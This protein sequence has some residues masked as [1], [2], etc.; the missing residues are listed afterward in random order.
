[1]KIIDLSIPIE[2]GMRVYPGDPEVVIN[3]IHT[4]EKH[5]WELRQL[6]MGS[7]TGTHVDAFS[8]MHQ[9]G[10]SIEQIPLTKFFGKAMVFKHAK[11]LMD[12]QPEALG[13]FFLEEVDAD[14]LASILQTNPP[15]VGG[16]ITEALERALLKEEVVTYTNLINLEHIPI[17][18]PFTF[19]GFPLNIKNGD[20]SPVR[21]V[22][23]LD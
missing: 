13:L 8:H 7:H 23:F 22:A 5:T 14:H 12:I 2:T 1:M 15:F 21:A 10:K 19:Y 11:N 18:E 3:R 6:S 16:N 17:E 20:G 9:G 4:Y